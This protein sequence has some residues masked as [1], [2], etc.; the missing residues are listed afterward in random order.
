MTSSLALYTPHMPSPRTYIYIQSF[1]TALII[2]KYSVSLRVQIIS[3][4]SCNLEYQWH[5][6]YSQVLSTKF[7]TNHKIFVITQSKTYFSIHVLN[8]DEKSKE[9]TSSGKNKQ[10]HV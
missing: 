1:L 4:G 9:F 2:L 7:R 5:N 8:L 3:F 10:I 6:D